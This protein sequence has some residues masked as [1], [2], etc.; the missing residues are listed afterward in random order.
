MRSVAEAYHTIRPHLTQWLSASM[1]NTFEDNDSE[2]KVHTRA[3]VESLVTKNPVPIPAEMEITDGTCIVSLN[4]QLV[5]VVY[6]KLKSQNL[7]T[8]LL[9]LFMLFSHHHHFLIRPYIV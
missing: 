9:Q 8:M 6:P 2:L 1:R 5:R 4:L 7:N 3:I